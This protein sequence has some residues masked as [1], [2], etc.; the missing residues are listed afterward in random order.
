MIFENKYPKLYNINNRNQKN[1]KSFVQSLVNFSL[2]KCAK[3]QKIFAL[4]FEKPRPPA[5]KMMF[6]EKV[7]KV[8]S[9]NKTKIFF[10]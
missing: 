6:L 4:V 8:L 10:L 3:C 9:R 1:K 7:V 2:K 5:S